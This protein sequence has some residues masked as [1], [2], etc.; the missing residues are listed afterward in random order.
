LTTGQV[1]VGTD[2]EG[3]HPS[4][5]AYR[6]FTH[7]DSIKA[8]ILKRYLE[9]KGFVPNIDDYSGNIDNR[10]ATQIDVHG[11]PSLSSNRVYTVRLRNVPV[12]RGQSPSQEII[13]TS[14]DLCE[15][16]PHDCAKPE[17]HNVKDYRHVIN[18]MSGKRRGAEKYL[19]IHFILGFEF[20][21]DDL[22]KKG[23]NVINPFLDM[24]KIRKYEFFFRQIPYILKEAEVKCKMTRSHLDLVETEICMNQILGSNNYLEQKRK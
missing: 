22:K 13:H 12:Y 14:Y 16:P 4:D 24:T 23:F 3:H 19:D 18:L 1:Y 7:T 21:V 15:Y 9:K 20:A 5:H 6:I 10:G 2:W 11:I 8:Q 17:W